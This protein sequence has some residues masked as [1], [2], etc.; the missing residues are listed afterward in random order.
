MKDMQ[1][2]KRVRALLVSFDMYYNWEQI[3]KALQS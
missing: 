3:I 2:I 1:K